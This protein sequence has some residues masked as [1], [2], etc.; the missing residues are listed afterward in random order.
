V[1]EYYN[2]FALPDVVGT[3]LA[4]KGYLYNTA[5]IGVHA[6]RYGQGVVS[7]LKDRNYPAI[8]QNMNE[9][10]YDDNET[11][12]LGVVFTPKTKGVAITQ[13]ALGIKHLTLLVP[14]HILL[15]EL[16]EYP[17][18]NAEKMDDEYIRIVSLAIAY[19]VMK[20][21]GFVQGKITIS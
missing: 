16:E 1:A 18:E 20:K 15:Q 4:E 5:Y 14:S 12:T 19:D 8:Y 17:R 13:L 3:Q 10:G 11:D 2:Q 21:S 6:D 7:I 9:S